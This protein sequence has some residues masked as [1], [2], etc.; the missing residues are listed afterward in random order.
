[1]NIMASYSLFEMLK[2]QYMLSLSV[3]LQD[4][5]D[6]L[7]L[8][9]TEL[10]KKI[11]NS[12][13]FLNGFM[14]SVFET[15]FT[16]DHI[17]DPELLTQVLFKTSAGIQ[18]LDLDVQDDYDLARTIFGQPIGDRSKVVDICNILLYGHEEAKRLFFQTEDINCCSYNP[19]QLKLFEIPQDG[20]LHSELSK[21]NNIVSDL[22]VKQF[23]KTRIS[24]RKDEETRKNT[25]RMETY[26]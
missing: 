21:Y 9:S 10:V 26:V 8:C 2:N 3:D 22:I 13:T 14:D 5:K 6:R 18:G 11:K 20:F 23:E 17:G 25:E 16:K 7:P 4:I 12:T 19:E 1:M 15:L 24:N